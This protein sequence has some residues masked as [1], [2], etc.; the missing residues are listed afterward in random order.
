MWNMPLDAG[1]MPVSNRIQLKLRV[2][3][4]RES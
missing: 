1:G 3:L 4:I 2:E